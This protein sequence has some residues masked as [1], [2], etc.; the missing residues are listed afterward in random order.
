MNL[1][2]Q[3]R[4]SLL[5]ALSLGGETILA[6]GARIV[7]FCYGITATAKSKCSARLLPATLE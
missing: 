2:A 3:R 6:F 1:N 4:P 7:I 5:N